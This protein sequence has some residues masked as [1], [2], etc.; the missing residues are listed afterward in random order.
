[1]GLTPGDELKYVY[2]FGDWI[3]HRII[4]DE[5]AEPEA[6]ASYP[7]I[8]AQNK[9]RYQHCQTCQDKGRKTVATWM[10]IE[11]SNEQHQ[12]VLVCKK[13]LTAEHEEHYADEVVY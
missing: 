11:C 3:E 8:V 5:I 10:C 12:R 7:R 9:P 4:L 6:R 2:D 13:C 1:L